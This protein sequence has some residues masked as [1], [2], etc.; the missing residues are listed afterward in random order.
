MC[1]KIAWLHGIDLSFSSCWKLHNVYY[2]ITYPWWTFL[3][4]AFGGAEYNSQNRLFIF[5]LLV[6]TKHAIHAA[7]TFY[8]PLSH[9]PDFVTLMLLVSHTFFPSSFFLPSNLSLSSSERE[10]PQ[11]AVGS[12]R[13]ITKNFFIGHF[14]SRKRPPQLI[15]FC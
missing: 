10:C 5:L 4:K 12:W 8:S 2:V 9:S 7:S 3:L 15:C 11:D 14:V 13:R 1:V 6:F